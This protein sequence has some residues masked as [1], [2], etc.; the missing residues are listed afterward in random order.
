[1]TNKLILMKNFKILGLIL[2]IAFSTS[3][4]KDSNDSSV[5]ADVIVVAKKS[6]ANTVYALAYYAYAYSSI[7]SVTV[8][9][10]LNP[11]NKVQLTSNGLYTTNFLKEPTDADFTTTKPSPDTFTF[12]TVFESGNTY[13]TEEEITSDILA[14]ITIEKCTYNVDKAYVELSWTPLTNADS[15][16]ITI[17]DDSQ[18]VVFRSN[19]FSSSATTSG[20]LTATASGWSTGHPVTGKPYTVRVFGYKYEDSANP[21]SYHIQ[22]TSYSDSS[23]IWGQAN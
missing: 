18:N 15:Y 10:A 21:N 2:L 1:M 5:A 23:I 20:Y 13:E 9:S 8:Q 17:Y 14:P 16:V 4:T 22:A 11:S 19:E 3:C 12:T 7:K 6:G